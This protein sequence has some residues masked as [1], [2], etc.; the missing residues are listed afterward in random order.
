MAPVTLHVRRDRL[1][2]IDRCLEVVHRSRNGWFAELIDEA[3]PRLAGEAD[4]KTRKLHGRN[5]DQATSHRG[6]AS[7]R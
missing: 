6:R 3:L 1:A 4:E 7:G 2:L 5:P